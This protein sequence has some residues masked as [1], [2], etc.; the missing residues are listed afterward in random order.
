MDASLA[1][2]MAAMVLTVLMFAG[3]VPDWLPAITGGTALLM[4]WRRT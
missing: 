2:G 3:A 4:A 1:L